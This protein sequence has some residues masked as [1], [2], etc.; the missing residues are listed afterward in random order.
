[1]S[2][3][4]VPLS[5]LLRY[6]RGERRAIWLAIACSVTNKLLDLAPPYLIGMAVDVVVNRENSLIGWFGYTDVIAQL[7]VL[8]IVTIV[9]WGFESIFEYWLGILWRNLAQRL[10]HSL[11]LDAYGHVQRLDLSY[12]EDRSTGGL[13][14]VL[15]DDVNQLERFLDGGANDLIQLGVTAVATIVTFFIASPTLAWIAMA[16]LPF[17]IW[18]SLLFQKRVA[19]RYADVR[20]KAGLLASQL[21]GNIGGIATVKS[22]AAEAFEEER[23]RAESVEYVESNR[24]AIRMSAAFS[25]LIRMVIVLGFGATV[26]YGGKLTLDGELDVGTY[27][28]L[29][30]LTQ[31]LLWPFTRLGQ[32]LDLYQR[33]MASASRIFDLLETH[34]A[35]KDGLLGLEPSQARGDVRFDRVTF[36]YVPGLPVLHDISLLFEAG[37]TTAIVGSTGGGKT[38]VL[39]LLLRLYDNGS[40]TSTLAGSITISGVEIRSLRLGDLRRAIAVVSQDVFLFHGTVAENIAYGLVGSATA[41]TLADVPRPAIERAARLSEAEEF[42]VRLPQGYETLVGERG[43]KL[44]GGQRQRIAMARAILKDAPILVL[45]EATSSVDNETEL[46]IQRSLATVCRDRTT[47]VIA[48]RLSTIRNAD[49]IHVLDEGRLVESGDHDGLVARGGLYATLWRIQTGEGTGASV[50]NESLGS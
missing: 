38:T 13:V 26:V 2:P 14:A 23:I 25:P 50:L 43:Q 18:G 24:R 19:P 6:A 39:K 20:E 15:N 45:D 48:H 49:R 33:G 3:V 32:V 5:R 11:R 17:V 31:R 42:I 34:V 12:F 40:G 36:S 10:Q 7:W 41:A 28:L 9:V 37:K 46:A 27:S 21:S 16:P 29:T 47:I 30:F 35:V 8:A 4:P 22:Y 44:S 1:M